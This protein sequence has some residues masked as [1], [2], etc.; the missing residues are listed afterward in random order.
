MHNDCDKNV[1]VSWSKWQSLFATVHGKTSF[2][3]N[4]TK[5]KSL[6]HPDQ[7]ETQ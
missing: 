7:H 2:T 6:K 3:K 5:K 1:M 4:F